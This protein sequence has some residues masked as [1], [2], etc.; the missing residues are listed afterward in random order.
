MLSSFLSSQ[1]SINM[2]IFRGVNLLFTVSYKCVRLEGRKKR[3]VSLKFSKYF[4]VENIHNPSLYFSAQFFFRE[5]FWPRMK[6]RTSTTYASIWVKKIPSMVNRAS[7]FWG[8]Y[9]VRLNGMDF[10][11]GEMIFFL[12]HPRE[13]T[14]KDSCAPYEIV[15]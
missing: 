15:P 12:V 1:I 6:I 14:S 8:R 10:C 3:K 7:K 11:M 2:F 9:S 5:K 4:Q 13:K